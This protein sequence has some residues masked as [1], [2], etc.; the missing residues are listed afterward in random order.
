MKSFLSFILI[1][2][3]CAL[4]AQ[5]TITTNLR[6]DGVFNT[7][8]LKWDID[9]TTEGLTVFNF[10]KDL[11]SFRHI[12]GSISSNYTI[13]DWTYDDNEVLYEMIITSDA[14]NE[15]DFMIDGTNGL[16]IF[17]YY[18]EYGDYRMVRHLIQDSYFDK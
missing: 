17:F 6:E 8:T 10:N 7:S 4:Q 16:V 5:L 3:Y 1:G 13:D 14:G 18:D 11:T 12:T 9:K 2:F 15:Y